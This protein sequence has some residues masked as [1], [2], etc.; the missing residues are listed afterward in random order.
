MRFAYVLGF[1]LCDWGSA[2][3]FSHRR[4]GIL[5]HFLLGAWRARRLLCQCLGLLAIR[6]FRARFDCRACVVVP[7]L[8]SLLACCS[9]SVFDCG[10]CRHRVMLMLFHRLVVAKHVVCHSSVPS[11]VVSRL[12]LSRLYKTRLTLLFVCRWLLTCSRGVFIAC[13][14]ISPLRFGGGVP[15]L[16]RPSCVS[17]R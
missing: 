4:F 17:L 9:P 10:C 7:D 3:W 13:L 14:A 1:S 8:I 2:L 16:C 12:A 15:L 6:P 11:I 5:N